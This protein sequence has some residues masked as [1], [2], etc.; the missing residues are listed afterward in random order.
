MTPL[1]AP[2]EWNPTSVPSGE[3][4]VSAV[5]AA[6]FISGFRIGLCAPD[7]RLPCHR[8][9]LLRAWNS[10]SMRTLYASVPTIKESERELRPRNKRSDLVQTWLALRSE[11]LVARDGRCIMRPAL[12]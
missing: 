5:M 3:V 8:V 1:P 2:N 12:Y 9:V 7:V 4:P 10:T 6:L 11:Q